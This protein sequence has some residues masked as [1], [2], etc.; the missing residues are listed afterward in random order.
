EKP[1][2]AL[3]EVS[4]SGP[5]DRHPEM[6]LAVLARLLHVADLGHL[7]D[8]L[9]QG[10][11]QR[12]LIQ[13]AVF[14]GAQADHDIL[15]L[16]VHGCQLGDCLGQL[17]RTVDGHAL[18]HRHTLP[19]ASATSWQGAHRMA[20]ITARRASGISHPHSSQYSC[21]SPCRL[22]RMAAARSSATRRILSVLISTSSAM[23]HLPQSLFPEPRLAV[24]DYM[25]LAHWL[26]VDDDSP[27][28]VLELEVPFGVL[29][30]LAASRLA[31]SSSA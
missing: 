3:T 25:V 8:A 10:E 26:A 27:F 19:F 28:A 12:V 24:L 31:S 7:C 11:P 18:T 13:G 14:P 17:C 1:V 21:P 16:A 20:L 5:H 2:P 29:H 9:V 23:C 22:A 15:L 30:R 4:V 6:Q